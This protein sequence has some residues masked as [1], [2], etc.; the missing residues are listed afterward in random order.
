MTLVAYVSGHGF[1]HSTRTAEVL[2]AVR[3]AAP[4]EPLAVVT[5]APESLFRE[6]AFGPF[7][8]RR[9]ACDVGLVQ[10]GALVI[11][12]DET[13]A[14]ARAFEAERPRLVES[15]AAW[16]RAAG[17][18][19]V[20]A[21]VPPLAFE[22]AAAAGVP[23][24]GLA[25]FSWDW[26]Y[27]H[28]AQRR[29]GFE[30]PSRRAAAAYAQAGLLLQLPFA[31]DL[32]AFPRREAIPMVA[33][34]RQRAR[35]EARRLLGFGDAPTVL[36]SFGGLGLPDFDPR[37]LAGLSRYRFVLETD[38]HPLPAN[39]RGVT[40]LRLAGLGLRYLDL[41]GAADVVLTKPG[42]GIVTD[43]IA[44]GTRILYTDRGDFP[45]YP[46]LAA[47][48]PRYLPCAHVSNED[49]RRGLLEEALDAVLGAPFPP[50]PRLDGAEVAAQRL[51]GLAR[52]AGA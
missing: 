39:V 46:I 32:A 19:L 33:R 51:L 41:I 28:L 52:A 18:T 11:D 25:N 8:Y 13:L 43:C 12:E 37:V 16:L 48:M 35:A 14:R 23:S 40:R 45:E 44:A 31:G 50:P 42:Y 22:A 36:V 20:L 15:E 21:D 1:G 10:K 26:I 4:R 38:E 29:A 27:R 6:A 9:L 3:E 47:E 34:R 7:A 30:E 2:R 17:A 49:V 5:S 24:V